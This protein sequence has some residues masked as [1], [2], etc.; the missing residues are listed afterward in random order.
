MAAPEAIVK[1]EIHIPVSPSLFFSYQASLNLRVT[2]PTR[3]GSALFSQILRVPQYLGRGA[4]VL[5]YQKMLYY[6]GRCL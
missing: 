1:S 2:R 5:K 4:L 3:V 6:L